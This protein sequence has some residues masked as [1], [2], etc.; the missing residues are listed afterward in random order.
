MRPLAT[1]GLVV[2]VVTATAA[3]VWVI[4]AYTSPSFLDVISRLGPVATGV[5]AV[6][7]LFVGISTIRQ[8]RGAD[9]EVAEAAR[10]DQWW[11][12]AQWSIDRL[13]E[14]P[15]ERQI[16]AWRVADSGRIESGGRGGAGDLPG[17]GRRWACPPEP[18]AICTSG[19]PAPDGY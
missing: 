9:A 5:V 1:A 13:Y 2:G 18:G 15:E 7:A 19:R 4:A 12:R 14:P 16:V 17:G 3:V 6:S 11:K 8:K 10:R